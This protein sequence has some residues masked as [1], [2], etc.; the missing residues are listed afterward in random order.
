MGR[1]APFFLPPLAAGYFVTEEQVW[2]EVV[3]QALDLAVAAYEGPVPGA[4][5]WHFITRVA[6]EKGLTF[7]PRANLKFLDFLLQY[8][9]VVQVVRRHETDLLVVPPDRP[10]LL[11]KGGQF[12]IVRNDLFK[13]LTQ[14]DPT[15]RPHYD[16]SRD[17]VVWIDAQ[18]QATSP[19]LVPLPKLTLASEM[20]F[21]QQFVGQ[22][23]D[24]EKGEQLEAALSNPRPL[25]AFERAV[26]A[27]GVQR[28]WY[29]YRSEQVLKRLRDWATESSIPWQ[30]SWIS[31][32][33]VP[34]ER[35]AATS[36]GRKA[37]ELAS[38]LASLSEADLA[39]IS[40]PLDILAK[41]LRTR[42]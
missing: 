28:E 14:V 36:A 5:L 30:E 25:P 21:R 13:A 12:L 22:V 23:Q 24:A 15:H 10:E 7:P 20:G 4:R 39:R 9:D 33:E 31:T 29:S 26:H 34:V 11:T 18:S 1:I 40:V 8:P 6:Q 19:D 35:T 16:K 3:A 32:P 37:D 42:S 41:L 38:A 2:R 27:A 17:R